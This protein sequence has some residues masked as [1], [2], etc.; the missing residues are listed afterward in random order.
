[1][2]ETD[3]FNLPKRKI[4]RKRVAVEVAAEVGAPAG[5]APAP[6]RNFLGPTHGARTFLIFLGA[7]AVLSLLAW[8]EQPTLRLIGF[9]SPILATVSYPIWGLVTRLHLRA[10]LRERFAD[11]CYYLGFIFTQIALVVG[12]LPV[13]LFEREISSS[14]VLRFFGMALGSSLIGLVV[15]TLLG[16]TTHS[17]P[18]NADI[19][20][21]EVDA[22]ARRVT[23]QT[24]TVLAE[25]DALAS[26]LGESQRRVSGEL[27]GSVSSLT[28]AVH[29][30]ETALRRDTSKIEEN[31]SLVSE[32]A[33][34]TEQEVRK[35][36]NELAEG[37]QVAAQA[38]AGM[39]QDLNEQVSQ[40]IQSIRSTGDGLRAST[41]TLQGISV[42]PEEVQGLHDTLGRLTEKI[43][44][45][46]SAVDG[47][48]NDARRSIEEIQG[49]VQNARSRAEADAAGLSA[50]L[51][52][53]VT[54][55]EQALAAFRQE[56]AR[57]RV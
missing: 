18:E 41:S 42:L 27:E 14:D 56:L 22:L 46:E 24:K 53:T 19:V 49:L 47:A 54:A 16:Q 43:G 2:S 1:M 3:L 35:H 34:G 7:G 37:V 26:G 48:Q 4:R 55:L 20:E 9:L 52:G 31:T 21:M 29:S 40:A 32:A 36:R 10:A 28:A 5:A 8:S 15:R 45:L 13:A 57:L 12:F 30:F 50:E 33:I 44:G 23:A 38:I 6:D 11:N 17:V 39:R 25:F 51:E